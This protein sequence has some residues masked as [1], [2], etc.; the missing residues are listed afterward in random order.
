MIDKLTKK[1][2]YGILDYVNHNRDTD[3]YITHNNERKFFKTPADIK[4]ILKSTGGYSSITAI[5]DIDGIAF[6]WKSLGNN[7]PRYYLKITAQ[8]TSI[9]QRVL[10]VLLWHYGHLELYIKINKQNSLL[11]VLKLHGFKF[12][13]DRGKEILLKKDK[14]ILPKRQESKDKADDID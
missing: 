14:F 7:I 9:G 3:F 1:D 12:F 13:G 8:N 4:S 11:P 6:I 2:L 5:G 10:K